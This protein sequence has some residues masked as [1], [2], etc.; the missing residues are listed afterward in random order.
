MSRARA[1]ALGR[2]WGWLSVNDIRRLENQS[3]IP[4]GDVYLEPTNMTEAGKARDNVKAMTEQI[5]KMLL[6]KEVI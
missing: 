2:Q 6:D 4:N 5:Y 1:Y 3:P